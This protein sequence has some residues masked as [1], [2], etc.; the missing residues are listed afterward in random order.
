[1]KMTQ[2]RAAWTGVLAVFTAVAVLLAKGG[3][4]PGPDLQDAARNV[5][6]QR[7]P[8]LADQA[9]RVGTSQSVKKS[10]A[11]P[12]RTSHRSP[13]DLGQIPNNQLPANPPLK[14]NAEQREAVASLPQSFQK[15]VTDRYDTD[16]AMEMFLKKRMDF[17]QEPRD[18]VWAE[19][20]EQ[21]VRKYW[22]TQPS[23]L[24]FQLT[25]VSCGTAVCELLAEDGNPSLPGQDLRD[26]TFFALMLREPWW[27]GNMYDHDTYITQLDGRLL[28][29]GYLY[30]IPSTARATSP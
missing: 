25:S 2:H 17:Q 26:Q 1:M 6:V 30:R 29:W 24:Q 21:S 20:T 7:V 4:V 12:I 16:P 13:K 9:S 15:I 28:H 22:A 3:F 23:S 14:W 27:V 11:S 19:R 8:Q 10:I 5:A 18:D